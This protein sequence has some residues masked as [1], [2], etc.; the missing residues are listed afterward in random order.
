MSQR[1]AF[2]LACGFA[3]LSLQSR[4]QKPATSALEPTRT[5]AFAVSIADAV[6][7]VDPDA[8]RPPRQ[9]DAFVEAL[10]ARGVPRDHVRYLR[11]EDAKKAL[12]LAAMSDHLR[13]AAAGDTL[14][15]YFHGRAV[16]AHD[17]RGF[18]SPY[19]SLKDD[20]ASLLA[21]D[22]FLEAVDG[23]FSGARVLLFMDCSLGGCLY[24]AL[25]SRH[26]R[27]E[28]AVLGSSQSSGHG[29]DDWTF[30]ES[31]VRALSGNG[32]IDLDNNG[33]IELKELAKAATEDC[34]LLAHEL[35][36]H[37]C[38]TGFPSSFVLATCAP[39]K[40]AREGRLVE[41]RRR[42]DRWE[43][44]RVLQVTQNRI[45]VRPIRAKDATDEGV[46]PSRV[47]E[48]RLAGLNPHEP[49]DILVAGE[50]RA[51]KVVKSGNGMNCVRLDGETGTTLDEWVGPDRLRPRRGGAVSATSVTIR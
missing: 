42:D 35:P 36:G 37:Q 31:L 45:I 11:D 10:H 4:A 8:V 2:W 17:G 50:W 12:I 15:V 27:H 26:W 33:R 13:R 18:L 9:D 48:P 20:S 14:V 39:K 40:S 47:R 32:W 46:E 1:I 19:D 23:S 41:V 28:V 7:D 6:E 3:I 34:V 24:D 16:R 21:A 51:G 30:S 44:A 25:P 43:L 49:V 22:E 5:W 29:F 38:S